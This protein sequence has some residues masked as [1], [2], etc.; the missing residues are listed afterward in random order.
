MFERTLFYT[1]KSVSTGNGMGYTGNALDDTGNERVLLQ[2]RH[3]V[4]EAS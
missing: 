4:Q 3:D 2:Q 1:Y